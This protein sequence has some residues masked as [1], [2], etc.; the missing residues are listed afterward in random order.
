MD[1]VDGA[2]EGVLEVPLL[3]SFLVPRTA[4][5]VSTRSRCG[6]EPVD[7]LHLQSVCFLRYMWCVVSRIFRLH[8]VT[9]HPL[10]HMVWE[11]GKMYVPVRAQSAAFTNASMS[12]I[13]DCWRLLSNH[14]D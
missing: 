10:S 2:A 1:R 3:E 12:T 13:A 14:V 8:T 4:S 9:T 5:D 11:S 6:G 7:V